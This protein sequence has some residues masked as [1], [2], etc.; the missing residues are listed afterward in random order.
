VVG[1]FAPKKRIGKL[2]ERRK[3]KKT[4]IVVRKPVKD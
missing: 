4:L 3:T 1:I 2:R